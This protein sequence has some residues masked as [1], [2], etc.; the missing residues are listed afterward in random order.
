MIEGVS[1]TRSILA[2]AEKHNV[3]MPIASAMS[4]IL[5]D[6]RNVRDAINELMTRQLRSE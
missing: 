4:S 3:E 5:F 1:T 6:E 2:L